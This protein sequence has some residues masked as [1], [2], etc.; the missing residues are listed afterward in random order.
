[1]YQIAKAVVPGMTEADL[2]TENGIELFTHAN[3]SLYL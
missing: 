2:V 1:M 3:E